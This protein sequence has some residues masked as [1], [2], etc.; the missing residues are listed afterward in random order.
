MIA[1]R[2]WESI[3][4][5]EISVILDWL[6]WDARQIWV[7]VIGVIQT[8]PFWETCWPLKII[9]KAPCSITTDVHTIMLNRCEK[10]PKRSYLT[11]GIFSMVFTNFTPLYKKRKIEKHHTARLANKKCVLLCKKKVPFEIV[12]D[13]EIQPGYSK[14]RIFELVLYWF[15]V[16]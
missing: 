10:T 1:V 8:K 9:H 5:D 12:V 11:N 14:L 6:L 4:L 13:Y 7:T 16:V 15:I 3:A 2:V